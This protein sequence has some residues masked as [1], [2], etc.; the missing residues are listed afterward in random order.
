MVISCNTWSAELEKA[1]KSRDP[2][3]IMPHHTIIP[4]L[5]TAAIC[6]FKQ[7]KKKTA[8]YL[9]RIQKVKGVEIFLQLSRKLHQVR[10]WMAG[11]CQVKKF[12]GNG[13]LV[14]C[15]GL[16]TREYL[17]LQ[18]DK[19]RLVLEIDGQ[20]FNLCDYPNVTYYGFA[21]KKWRRKLLSEAGVLVQP[22]LYVE[23]F[24]CNVIEAHLSGTPVVASDRG[25]FLDTIKH[26]YNGYHCK[27]YEDY[28]ACINKC[29]QGTIS[30]DDC[31]KSTKQYGPKAIYPKYIDFFQTLKV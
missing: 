16:S 4:P 13:S 26:G 15:S 27:T 17:K 8:L 5:F 10:F 14:D 23:P 2:N 12:D 19:Q 9:A 29:L 7:H 6:T 24:G 21:N 11:Y 28:V 1:E 22:T 18:Q 20:V 25:G 30:A 3:F 31:L